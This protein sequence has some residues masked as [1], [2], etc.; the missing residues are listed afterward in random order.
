MKFGV[1]IKLTHRRCY[2]YWLCILI[3]TIFQFMLF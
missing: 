2:S 3:L 1:F